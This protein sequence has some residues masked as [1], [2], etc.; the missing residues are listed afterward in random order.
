MK[1][2]GISLCRTGNKLPRFLDAKIRFL[3]DILSTEGE[4]NQGL[5]PERHLICSPH[6]QHYNEHYK[7]QRYVSGVSLFPCHGDRSD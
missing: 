2:R 4:T 7:I 1:G 6:H 3:S 5:H